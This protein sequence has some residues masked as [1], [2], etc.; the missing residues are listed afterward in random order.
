M[1]KNEDW[2]TEFRRLRDEQLINVG[3]TAI[4]AAE[5]LLSM[6]PDDVEVFP[7]DGGIQLE[8]TTEDNE[9]WELHIDENGK[10]VNIY[11]RDLDEPISSMYDDDWLDEDDRWCS[12]FDDDPWDNDD[13]DDEEN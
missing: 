6:M 9:Y 12:R 13:G 4:A 8:R 3:D 10:V 7:L 11:W 1:L 5:V 2:K